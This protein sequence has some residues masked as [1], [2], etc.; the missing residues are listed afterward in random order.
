MQYHLN[1]DKG[2][3]EELIAKWK[4]SEWYYRNVNDKIGE[5]FDPYSWN[6]SEET[7]RLVRDI[8]E[9]SDL[10]AWRHEHPEW[11]PKSLAERQRLYKNNVQFITNQPSGRGTASLAK[12]ISAR[13]LVMKN[14]KNQNPSDPRNYA[15]MQGEAGVPQNDAENVAETTPSWQPSQH[16]EN[17]YD[18]PSSSTAR[19]QP[20]ERT[21]RWKAPPPERTVR[22]KAPPA[23]PPMRAR[24]SHDRRSHTESEQQLDRDYYRREH[25][26]TEQLRRDIGHWEQQGRPPWNEYWQHGYDEPR[27]Y[28]L[29]AY[30]A[31]W[32]SASWE[33]E[34]QPEPPYLPG[35]HS[36]GAWRD[37]SET[38]EYP[39]QE[40]A[41]RA[42]RESRR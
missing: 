10:C 5:Y 12:I 25:H 13:H 40:A 11:K 4:D 9:F 28:G 20:P 42:W 2:D 29:H 21:I 15:V 32:S 38:L 22:W 17:Y 30:A 36:E 7:Y 18:A 33:R 35:W 24:D 3:T 41:S 31:R 6:Y 14:L 39:S 26:E 34:E 16:Y 27:E 37:Y 23:H 8:G 19:W 1:F